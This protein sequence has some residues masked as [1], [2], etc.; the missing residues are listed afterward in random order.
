MGT[1]EH[2]R[3]YTP[4]KFLAKQF[5]G[6]YNYFNYPTKNNCLRGRIKPGNSKNSGYIGEIFL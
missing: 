4:D 1:L 5:K 6:R 2:L 3:H